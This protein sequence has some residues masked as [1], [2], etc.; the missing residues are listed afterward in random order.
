MSFQVF[1]TTVVTFKLF[2]KFAY[3][4]TFQKLEKLLEEKLQQIG[5]WSDKG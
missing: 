4:S 2:V 3:W 5:F 1:V